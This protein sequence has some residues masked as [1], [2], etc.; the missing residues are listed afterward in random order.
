MVANAKYSKCLVVNRMSI[1]NQEMSDVKS[2]NTNY[3]YCWCSKVEFFRGALLSL[4][5]QS[6]KDS[7]A[8]TSKIIR[9]YISLWIHCINP[10][11]THYYKL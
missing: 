1:P 9:C 11:T 6:C 5:L 2:K 10:L 3:Y 8:I 4:P 7:L